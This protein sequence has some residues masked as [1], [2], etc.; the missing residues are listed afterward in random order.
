MKNIKRKVKSIVNH[1]LVLKI[2]LKLN[3]LVFWWYYKRV[4]VFFHKW[5]I[6]KS[7]RLLKQNYEHAEFRYNGLWEASLKASQREVEMRS[8]ISSLK[9]ELKGVTQEQI[10]PM[11]KI[12]GTD[13][14]VKSKL[15]RL[16]SFSEN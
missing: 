5:T 7:I 11:N 9:L 8:E 14:S 12:F 1:S 15:E 10:D 6:L 16:V 3:H 2:I 13:I 4:P